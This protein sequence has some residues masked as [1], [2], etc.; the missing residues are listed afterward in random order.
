MTEKDD[1]G[2]KETPCETKQSETVERI[3][4]D[5]KVEV[6]ESVNKKLSAMSKEAKTRKKRKLQKPPK[7]ETTSSAPSMSTN[8]IFLLLGV[9][10]VIIAGASLYYQRKSSMR[11]EQKKEKPLIEIPEEENE[12][13][14]RGK[15]FMPF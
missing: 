11:K 13:E 8:Q 5:E 9:V 3:T 4:N 2:G 10:G 6:N 7:E 12:P 14:G 15:N 1:K